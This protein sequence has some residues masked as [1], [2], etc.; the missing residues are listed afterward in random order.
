MKTA[1]RHYSLIDQLCVQ[2]EQG[3]R[4]LAGVKTQDNRPS[5]SQGIPEAELTRDERQHIAGLMRVNHSGEVCAQAL[6]FGQALMAR[7]P[8]I[9]EH[10]NQAAVEEGD[11]LFWC[12]ERIYELGG[13]TSLLNPAWYT[14]SVLI[15][16]FA[17]CLGDEKSLGFIA[18]TEAQVEQHL[19][20]HLDQIPL[21]D[22]RT[23]RVIEQ[24]QQDE[25]E[26]GAHAI[27]AGGKHL[28]DTT[29]SIMRQVAKVMTKLA[30]YL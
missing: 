18:A 6:Y 30:Y 26:H 3:L 21:S 8:E 15:G 28:S 12:Q 5:P 4:L 9:R 19:Q 24:M 14:F 7:T 1:L 17:A 16:M 20:S 10:M 29:Q 27:T 22:Q 13:R 25:I 11:H 23:R 2:A